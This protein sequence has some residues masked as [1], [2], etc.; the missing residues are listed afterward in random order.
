M[1]LKNLFAAMVLSLA[2]LTTT[3]CDTAKTLFGEVKEPPLKGD[4]ISV[5]Q[6]QGELEPDPILAS[7]QMEL[8]ASWENSFWPQFGGYPSHAMGHLNLSM[9]LK[10]QWSTSIGK[11]GKRR[12]PLSIQPIVADERIFTLDASAKLSAF[13]TSN[14]K[15][16][17]SVNLVPKDE[18]EIGTIGGG[19]AFA[20]GLLFV[21]S[22]YQQ[23]LAIDPDNGKTVWKQ[24]TTSPTR[25]APAVLSGRVL[26]ITLDNQIQA[27]NATDGEPLW[28]HSGVQETTNLL[29]SS[30]PAI[31]KNITIAALSSG[32]ILAL[33]SENGQVLWQDNLSSLRKYGALP[34]ISDIRGLPVIDRG[35]IYIIGSSGRMLALDEHTGRRLWQKEIGGA[36]TPWPAGD[37]IFTLTSNQQMVALGRHSGQIYWV[38]QL[39]TFVKQDNPDTSLVWTGPVMAGNRLILASN[40]GHILFL[41]PFTGETKDTIKFSDGT[42]IPPVVADDTLYILTQDAD[43]IAYSAE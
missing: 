24:K 5:L 40:R 36:E 35:I 25:S 13:H 8:P 6:Y 16:L 23:L 34:G 12:K 27:F 42:V 26:V 37:T 43:L 39:P 4:R 41:D 28:N 7:A 20:D 3:G 2:A 32:E 19:L 38:S 17:W 11:A 9:P 22:G 10:K 15:K 21:S 29:G 31:D 30:S 33:R 1:R 14:G 18:E